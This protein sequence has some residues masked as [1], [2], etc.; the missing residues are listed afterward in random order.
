MSGYQIFRHVKTV[1]IIGAMCAVLAGC[2]APKA[3]IPDGSNKVPVNKTVPAAEAAVP[4]A[5]SA[6]PGQ[7]GSSE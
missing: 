4:A 2:V 6:S 3:L 7:S 5:S 1:A